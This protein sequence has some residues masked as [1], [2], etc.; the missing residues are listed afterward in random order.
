[1][2]LG[3]TELLILLVLFLV[4]GIIDAAVRPDSAWAAAG[5]SKLVWVVVQMFLW[6]VGSAVHRHPAQAEGGGVGARGGVLCGG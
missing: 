4:W 5:Q 2:N 1:M 6:V 3:P